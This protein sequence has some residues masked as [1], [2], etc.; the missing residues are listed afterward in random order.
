M[1]SPTK[2]SDYTSSDEWSQI[3][4]EVRQ[5]WADVTDDDIRQTGGDAEKLV[6]VIHRKTGEAQDQV[7]QFV[8]EARERIATGVRQL[9][10]SASAYSA[11]A[12]DALQQGYDH[13]SARVKD[14]YV[15]AQQLVRRRPAES[16]AI[17]FG[18]GVVTGLVV[19]ALGSL[20]NR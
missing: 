7:Q 9:R 14:G 6:D 17:A 4:G 2:T 5:R 20:R 12:V 19:S 15:Q 18:I 8:D 16:I 1:A 10:E 11:D 3:S 13:A